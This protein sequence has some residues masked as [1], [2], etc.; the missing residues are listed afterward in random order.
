MLVIGNAA[1]KNISYSFVNLVIWLTAVITLKDCL[2]PI[3][4]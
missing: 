2:F 1:A 4:H 3:I